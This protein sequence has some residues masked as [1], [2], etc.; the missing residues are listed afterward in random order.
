MNIEASKVVADILEDQLS[1]NPDQV[2][3]TDQNRD[4]PE[5][6][7]LY[8]VVGNVSSEILFSNSSVVNS[9]LAI[10]KVSGVLGTDLSLPQFLHA[11]GTTLKSGVLT[12]P[13]LSENLTALLLVFD[14]EISVSL[15]SN[16]TEF[17]PLNFTA[18]GTTLSFVA[19]VLNTAFSSA[20]VSVSA[21]GNFIEFRDA[22]NKIFE[23]QGIVSS[24]SLQIDILSR[25][26]LARDSRYKVLLA[27]TSLFSQQKQEENSFRIF[28]IPTTFINSSVLEGGSKITRYTIRLNC[29]VGQSQRKEIPQGTTR[30]VYD[31]FP[32]RV[33]DEQ[34]IET[35]NGIIEIDNVA[36]TP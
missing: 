21:T 32:L 16:V 1:L 28:R 11:S 15:N 12:T 23:E 22:D 18:G 26:N 25:T 9:D 31:T 20:G 14:G 24:E 36:P 17:L 13:D 33:D 4:I 35:P 19:S 7:R 34:S 5:D 30:N 10:F 29:Y 3:V 8:V 6:N 27:L 2:W